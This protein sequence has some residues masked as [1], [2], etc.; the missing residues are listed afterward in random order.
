MKCTK[1]TTCYCGRECQRA[2]WYKHK[3][4]CNKNDLFVRL[5]FLD[6]DEKIREKYAD[7]LSSNQTVFQ[8]IWNS[9][10]GS[11]ENPVQ[12]ARKF[13]KFL[14]MCQDTE[15]LFSLWSDVVL[16]LACLRGL[17]LSPFQEKWMEIGTLLME[18]FDISEDSYSGDVFPRIKEG[19]QL[20]SVRPKM[21]MKYLDCKITDK[22]Q[23]CGESDDVK[24]CG[25]CQNVYY[26]NETCQRAD[27]KDHK[28]VCE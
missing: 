22:C 20:L 3:H 6:K 15:I 16:G 8:N 25:N 4:F 26:C 5:S 27:W 21:L 9:T 1:C 18:E 10:L 28:K 17:K 13:R 7:F 23:S 19:K 2:D 24:L 11:I 14:G 12:F